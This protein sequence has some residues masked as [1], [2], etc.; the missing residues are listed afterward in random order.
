MYIVNIFNLMSEL[1]IFVCNNWDNDYEACMLLVN[2]TTTQN[3]V[4]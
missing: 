4:G 1:S 2:A 3:E